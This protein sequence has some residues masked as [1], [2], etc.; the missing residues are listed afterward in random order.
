MKV[1]TY[2]YPKSSFLG[3]PKDAA[4]I[5]RKIISN[6]NVLRLLYYNAPDCLDR[7]KYPD[8]TTKDIQEM[9]KAEQ[10][11]TIPRVKIDQDGIKHSY[12]RVTFNSFTPNV[13]N[14]FYRDHVVEVRLICHFDDWNL[15]DFDQ[16]PY[17]LAG[18]I[19]AMLANQRFSGIGLLTFVGA[20]QDVYNSEY[21]G[22]T[23][24]YLAVRGNEDKVNPLS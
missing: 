12:L 20:N 18:E 17:R 16:R 14:N 11:L 2:E 10:I 6:Q 1:N 3:M 7:Q 21:A 5:M 15:L 19:D 13:K 4:A 24:R 23:L 8:V 22:L 9:I